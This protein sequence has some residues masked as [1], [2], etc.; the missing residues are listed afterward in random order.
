MGDV[1]INLA[2]KHGLNIIGIDVLDF[3]IADA[4]HRAQNQGV[5]KSVEF[6]V[7]S[8]SDLGF[9]SD[10][11]DAVYT[12]ETLVHAEDATRVLSEFWRV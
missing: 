12:M 5:A 10:H 3:N 6:L 8:Y 11:F 4:R 2:L 1:A 7:M 9:P